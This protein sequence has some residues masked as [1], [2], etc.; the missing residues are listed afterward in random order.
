MPSQLVQIQE[1]LSRLS[2]ERLM[3]VEDFIDFLRQ[4]DQD[5]YLRQTYAQMSEEAFN[6]IWDNDDDAVY[7]KL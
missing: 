6:Q 2:P 1:K 4:R 3:E 5:Q 7:D